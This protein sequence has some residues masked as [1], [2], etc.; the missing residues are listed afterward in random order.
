MQRI[1]KCY[2]VALNALLSFIDGDTE[3]HF[4]W[5]RWNQ[6]VLPWYESTYFELVKLVDIHTFW[7]GVTKY[8]CWCNWV[9]LQILENYIT[10]T[11]TWRY[12]LRVRYCFRHILMVVERHD[13]ILSCTPIVCFHSMLQVLLY[14]LPSWLVEMTSQVGHVTSGLELSP[15]QHKTVAARLLQRLVR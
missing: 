7:I 3:L 9:P 2:W 15:C 12:S 1:A 13:Q 5:E 8:H 6:V 11:W 10:Q 4:I 14:L